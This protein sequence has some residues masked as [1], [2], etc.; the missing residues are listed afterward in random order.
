MRTCRHYAILLFS[1]LL[2]AM[3]PFSSRAIDGLDAQGYMMDILLQHRLSI[4]E[5]RSILESEGEQ[6][7]PDPDLNFDEAQKRWTAITKQEW[8]R[9][10]GITVDGSD[11]YPFVF[12]SR[13]QIYVGQQRLQMMHQ[14]LQANYQLGSVDTFLSPT[15]SGGKGVYILYNGDD[16][17]CAL[18]RVPVSLAIEM[19]TD[20]HIGFDDPNTPTSLARTRPEYVVQPHISLFKIT[21]GSTDR[22]TSVFDTN[23][24]WAERKS[25]QHQ[26][27]PKINLVFCKGIV[28][29]EFEEI[30]QDIANNQGALLREALTNQTSDGALVAFEIV[31]NMFSLEDTEQ[32]DEVYYNNYYQA[33]ATTTNRK[34]FWDEVFKETAN[35]VCG[36]LIQA[37]TFEFD[38]ANDVL[39]V[40]I[41]KKPEDPTLSNSQAFVNEVVTKFC[42]IAMLVGLSQIDQV[43]SVDVAVD[44]EVGNIQSAWIS[45]S[46]IRDTFPWLVVPIEREIN[47]IQR[48]AYGQT[49]K[50]THIC[51]VSI[52]FLF[53]DRFDQGL[54]GKGQVVSVSDTG[55][56]M[57]NC[58]FYDS[59]GTVFETTRRGGVSNTTSALR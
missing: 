2:A 13:S 21:K 29:H 22:L 32:P 53:A 44:I 18:A 31:Y 26:I 7:L 34:D 51:V 54:T 3:L 41:P 47:M 55:L 45:Q 33:Q 25:Q 40:A 59:T 39:S 30:E 17:T 15:R 56:D 9:I 46:G 5:L 38:R 42:G 52:A 58:Y 37:A 10:I 57:K 27:I 24:T 1:S 12:C 19:A 48:L 6:E 28:N 16:L 50:L 36:D 20:N 23:S 14:K 43:C 49:T 4:Q 11:L 8:E 35:G